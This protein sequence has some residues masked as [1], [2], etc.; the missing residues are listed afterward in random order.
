MRK[1]RRVIGAIVAAITATAVMS[2]S[3]SP[4]QPAPTAKANKAAAQADA[5]WLL[6]QTVLPADATRL[7]AKPSWDAGE[8]PC[9][10]TPNAVDDAGWWQAPESFQDV[11]AFVEA[12]P[13][14]GSTVGG[15]GSS[16]QIGHGESSET[17][18][19]D[20]PPEPGVLGERTLTVS[21]I[22]LPGGSSGVRAD[23]VSVWITPRPLS[24]RVPQARLLR[25]TVTQGPK[26]LQGP[27]T[28]RSARK[29][30][31]VIALL[32]RLPA[33]QPG[34]SACPLDRGIRVVL[35][36]YA[37][38]RTQ[39]PAAVATI[40]VGGCG[41][42]GLRVHGHEE[43]PLAETGPMTGRY[44]PIQDRVAAIIGRRLRTGP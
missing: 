37:T 42:V 11:I 2:A 32:N 27:I 9:P 33:A 13:P 29:T 15:T 38:K 26:R 44:V 19:I 43:P 24:E 8:C 36:F 39:T 16:G 22:P 25:V 34:V 20:W 28:V 40:V 41:G 7:P 12:H 23:G 4:S 17:V 5:S 21:A 10:I 18:I 3:A 31:K 35:D 30:H 1:R 14:P 6:S